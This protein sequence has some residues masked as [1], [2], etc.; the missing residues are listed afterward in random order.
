M[1]SLRKAQPELVEKLNAFAPDL[2]A[3][4][5]A[6]PT[7][8][9]PPIPGARFFF[10]AQNHDSNRFWTKS[11]FS[12]THRLPT[13]PATHTAPLRGIVYADSFIAWSFQF[14][15]TVDIW[16]ISPPHP[17]A[18]WVNFPTPWRLACQCVFHTPS[19]SSEVRRLLSPAPT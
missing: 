8:G 13:I 12:T 18:A 7:T 14:V 15:A 9:R 11:T 16:R 2:I 6:G 17:D 3:T 19:V 1:K 10:K 5:R 4:G